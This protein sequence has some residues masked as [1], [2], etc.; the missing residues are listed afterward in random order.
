MEVNVLD[1]P[2]RVEIWLSRNEASSNIIRDGLKPTYTRYR[3][4][5]YR[6]VVFESGQRDLFA[7]TR[8]LLLGNRTQSISQKPQHTPRQA[9]R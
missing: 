7:T 5:G 6:V 4:K 2:K 9:A 3:D 1:D 8:D